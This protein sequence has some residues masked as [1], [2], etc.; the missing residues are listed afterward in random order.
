MG[1]QGTTIYEWI[2]GE[3]KKVGEPRLPNN[4]NF[5]IQYN[6]MDWSGYRD[7]AGCVKQLDELSRHP[8]PESF[9]IVEV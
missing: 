8:R 9:T 7:L 5:L 3:F 1:T 4:F 2:G 6:G